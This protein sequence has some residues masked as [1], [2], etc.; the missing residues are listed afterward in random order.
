MNLSEN[1]EKT[2]GCGYC[3]QVM[4]LT[5][6]QIERGFIPDTIAIKCVCCG[7]RMFPYTK[8]EKE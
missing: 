5:S 1:S 4:E 2:Y 3:G 8:E 6:K 7:G